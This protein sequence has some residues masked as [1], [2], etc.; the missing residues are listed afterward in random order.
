MANESAL[1][2]IMAI[3]GVLAASE[4][5][6]DGKATGLKGL[7]EDSKEGQQGPLYPALW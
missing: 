6:D 7:P 3:K 5:D 2:K 1:D 4:R